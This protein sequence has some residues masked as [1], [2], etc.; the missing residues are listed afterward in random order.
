MRHNNITIIYIQTYLKIFLINHSHN[1]NNNNRKNNNNKHNINRFSN[2]K[3]QYN[4]KTVFRK[5]YTIIL[6]SKLFIQ[7]DLFK[8]TEPNTIKKRMAIYSKIFKQT[9]K[10]TPAWK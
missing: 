3:I 5:K 2:K 1:N 9:F 4:S 7:K 8:N 10:K 6:T